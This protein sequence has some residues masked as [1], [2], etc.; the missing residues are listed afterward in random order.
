MT[1]L[2]IIL[3]VLIVFGIY[4]YNK[5]VRKKYEVDNATGSINAMLKNR[6]DLIPNLVDTVKVY[7][8]H[9][10]DVLNKL[11]TMRTMAMDGKISETDKQKIDS[12]IKDSMKHLMI[13]VE[14]Y[15]DLKANNNFLQLQESW[16]DIEDR[17]SASR[18]FY[19]TAVTEY[20]VAISSFPQEIIA[21]IMG[22]KL[23]EVF[24]ISE[25]EAKNLNSKQLFS[26]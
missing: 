26:R 18:R 19:N 9:E 10:T 16:T 14:N 20:N 23:K 7:M 4:L 6:Y 21:R 24:D 3:S 22:Y 25:E 2:F 12:E 13:S 15:P 1:T 17:I 5:L 8:T 11:T